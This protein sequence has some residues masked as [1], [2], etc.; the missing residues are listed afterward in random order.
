MLD[1]LPILFK[2]SRYWL[3]RNVCK[4]LTAGTRRVEFT[5]FWMGDQFCSFLYS[6]SQIYLIICLYVEGF[7]SNWRECGSK[8]KL[9]PISFV[10]AIL[11]FLVRLIQSIKRYVDSGLNTHMINGG[12]YG[13][14]IVS[15]LC[16]FIWRHKGGGYGPTFVAWIIFQTIYSFYALTWDLLMDWSIMHLH[17]RYPLLRKELVYSNHVY[18]YYVAI[19]S[20]TLI[21]FVWVFYIPTQ[22]P[23][24]VLRTFIAGFL[25]M[26]RRWQWNFY[27]VEN[28][29]LGN[30]DQYRVTR[31]VPLPYS[32]DDPRGEDVDDDEDGSPS[33]KW[34]P[35]RA[36]HLRRQ[37]AAADA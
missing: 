10:L 37:R 18:L 2:S 36:I 15:Y 8:S 24:I 14:G 11:P 13:A 7:N 30:V 17:V 26:L 3:I 5:D 19:V 35:Q 16:Y 29:H 21:R 4:L 31:E 22:G 9:W 20:N 34:F 25:E 6:L 32:L 12:K 27:R 1:P 33:R 23:D 28:E